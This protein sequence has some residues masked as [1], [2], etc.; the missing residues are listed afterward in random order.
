MA[1]LI[2]MSPTG[3]QSEHGLRAINTLGRHPDQTIQ[4]LD[5]VV[6]K[7]HALVTFAD[8]GYWLQD[9]S[10]RNGTFVNGVA[11]RGRTRLRDGD[12]ITL[13]STRIVYVDD[14]P[15]KGTP[16][17]MENVTIQQTTV[18]DSAIRSRVQADEARSQEFVPESQVA[19]ESTLRADYE[20]LRIAFELNQAIGT[21]LDIVVLLDKILEKAF[22]FTNADRGVI[23]LIDEEGEPRPSAFK[24]RRGREERVELSHTILNEVREQRT[25]VL[26]SDATM[27]SR[28]GG[29]HSI[30]MQGIRSTMCVP[31]INGDEL[32]GMIHLDTR[33]ATGVFTEKDLR[34]LTVFGNQAALK[35]ANARLAKKAESDAVVRHNLSRLLSPNLVDEVVKGT[36]AM[37]KG[38]ELREATV[39]FSD[40][41]GFTAMGESLDP[42]KMVS[43]LNEYFEIMVDIVFRHEGTLDKFIGDEI[44]AVWGAPVG[45]PDHAERAVKAAL[46]MMRALDDFNRA[47]AR[48]GQRAIQVGTGINTGR[49]VAG[50]MGSTRTLSYTVMGD[51][52]N[53]ASRLCSHAAPGEILVSEPMRQVLGERLVCEAREAAELKGKALRVPIYRVVALR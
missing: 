24:N 40:I 32:L 31:L 9:M 36:I 16:G 15:K 46:E 34:V 21:E 10:S 11:I 1:K 12:T 18:T 8:E 33:I 19:D 47:R 14:Q 29:A 2:V 7:E 49:L 28:F 23:L 53:T 35:I 13:G 17:P 22:E 45:Q 3:E 27:D 43:L 44:M 25:A 26:S 48:D 39:L 5:R 42:Q 52:V 20:K 41:R 38:G 51:T 4:V 37:Q 30:I 50:Y 6:S